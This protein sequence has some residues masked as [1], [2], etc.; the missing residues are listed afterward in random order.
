MF[1]SN[2][3]FADFYFSGPRIKTGFFV[4]SGKF[5]DTDVCCLKSESAMIV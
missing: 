3:M 2:L 4:K 5:S 1:M